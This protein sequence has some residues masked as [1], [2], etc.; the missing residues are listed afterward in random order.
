[1]IP[2]DYNLLDYISIAYKHVISD[3]RVDDVYDI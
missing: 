3:N 1:M 2:S